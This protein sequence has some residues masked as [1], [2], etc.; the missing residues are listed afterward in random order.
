MAKTIVV[1]GGPGS[2]KTTIINQLSQRGYTCFDEVSRSIIQEG[3][4]AGIDQ[5]FLTD[6]ELFSK[7]LLKGR[8]QQYIDA[9]LVAHPLVF[10]DRGIPDIVAYMNFKKETSPTSFIEACEKC[11]YDFVFLLPPWENIYKQD[12]ERYETFEESK[13][14]YENL[15]NAYLKYGYEVVEVPFGNLIDRVNYILNV[16]EYS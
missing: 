2:G 4:E 10:L 12:N 7:K 11:V 3:Q 15:K 1:S 9:K 16:V 8:I 5:L 14:I 13:A 6:P